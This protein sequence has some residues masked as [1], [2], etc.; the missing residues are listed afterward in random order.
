MSINGIDDASLVRDIDI[1]RLTFREIRRRKDVGNFQQ[2]PYLIALASSLLWGY[3]G[4]VSTLSNLLIT[5]NAFGCV[6][7][8]IYIA[9]FFVYSPKI[10]RVITSIIFLSILVGFGMLVALTQLYTTERKRDKIVGYVSAVFS[11]G[12]FS[13]P[14]GNNGESN[15]VVFC[16]R[17]VEYMPFLPALFQTLSATVWLTFGLLEHNYFIAVPNIDSL[18]IG[19]SQMVMYLIYKDAPKTNTLEQ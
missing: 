10:Q 11:F 1:N 19:I 9:L 2:Y 16:K 5:I 17:S 6:M 14:I 3:Y 13:C 8:M 15:W 12:V 18:I 7:E 4:V